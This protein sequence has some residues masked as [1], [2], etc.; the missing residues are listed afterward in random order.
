MTL[1]LLWPTTERDT[2]SWPAETITD[3]GLEA[4]IASLTLEARHHS[5]VRKVVLSAAS[6]PAVVVYRQ[7]IARD[8][9]ANPALADEIAAVLPLTLD[10]IEYASVR[11]TSESSPLYALI[12]RL[13][14]LNLYVEAVLKL[15]A[16]LEAS[17]D[18]LTSDGLRQW[19]DRLLAAR[20]DPEFAA[21]QTELPALLARLRQPEAIT[22]GINLDPQFRP[23]AATLLAVHT[24]PFKGAPESLLGRL[25][26]G[27]LGE[28]GGL[29]PLHVKQAIAAGS[30]PERDRTI[31]S[32]LFQD[33][34]KLMA[35]T[36]KPVADGIKRYVRVEAGWL[37]NTLSEAA[38]YLGG[39]RLADRLEASG[40]PVCL[41][42]VLP[43]AERRLALQDGYNVHLALRLSADGGRTTEDG[44]APGAVVLNDSALADSPGRIAVLTGPNR[45]GKTTF[46]QALGVAQVLGQAGLFV[47]ARAATLS[48]VD[49]IFTH[50]ASEE[51]P[52][53]EAGRLGEESGRVAA[54]F[55]LA[56]AHSLVLLN[57]TFASTS[58]SE[59]TY[60]ARDVLM[61][62]RALG[63]RAVFAT[64]LHDVAAE[65]DAL[66]AA[67][68]SAHIFSLV[69]TVAADSSTRTFKII[70]RPPE[71]QSYAR[72][73]AERYGVSYPQLIDRLRQR[74]VQP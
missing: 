65:L 44:Q 14:E 71:G 21:L 61:A 9:R 55:D 54:I 40:L 29:A 28:A 8:V 56:S 68:G 2:L 74:G 13:G 41:P 10:L 23:S 20:C 22:V 24:Q 34:E 19:R 12:G 11:R 73:I 32:P 26:G 51:R 57:E 31:L 36:V 69:A 58:P 60:L 49:R 63:A 39:V 35:E 67:P 45:G 3:L 6:D 1:S 5:L 33:L 16:A 38:V 43:A 46:V 48:V 59:G 47:P 27:R 62:L 18:R 15:S 64:H 50:F 17:G 30:L 7:A 70:A 37:I 4:L 52:G 25:L 66:N 53:Q 42:T 72:D